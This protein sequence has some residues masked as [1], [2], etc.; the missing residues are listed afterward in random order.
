[1][2]KKRKE[3]TE[4]EEFDFKNPK[5]D[6]EKFLKKER[7]N[8]KTMFIAFLFA[9]VITIISFGFWVLLNGNEQR[10]VLVL[11]FGIINA[12]WIKYLYLRLNIDL[13]DFG[14]KGWFGSYAVYFF[15]W[16]LVLIIIVNPPFYDGEKP[17]VEMVTLPDMQELGGTVNI[18]A[19]I[20]D[21]V[22]VEKQDIDFTLTYPD[23]NSTTIDDFSFNK[24]IFSYTYENPDNTPGKYS[25]EL[26]AEDKNGLKRVKQDNFTYTDDAIKLTE[27]LG[28]TDQNKPPEVTY[29]T[30]IKFDVKA[31]VS[32]VYY[33]INDGKE[34]NATKN[35]DYYESS[36][37]I[38]GW[39]R[40]TNVTVKVYAD[41]IHYFEQPIN[42]ES[43]GNS[44]IKIKDY[45]NTIIDSSTY[46]FNVSDAVEIG[47]EDSP[48]AK[49]PKPRL[50]AV[51]GFELLVFIISLMIV[52]FIFKYRKKDRRN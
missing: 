52:I 27:P 4:E 22:G 26:T 43:Y 23:G 47:G 48:P 30:T 14:K 50:I 11:L 24:H 18:V 12:A 36:P 2:A 31:D 34:I 6:E 16:L 25:Y 40:N 13:T 51:P 35:G 46:Y 17:N 1:M 3:K 29:S 10:W 32:R 15:A 9:I 41:I 42:L 21:N 8:I 7:R 20:I 45:N 49:L 28:A 19:R 39:P 5:F 33:T 37:K 44:I 38:E